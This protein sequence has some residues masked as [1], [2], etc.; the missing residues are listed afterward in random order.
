VPTLGEFLAR[1]LA[2]AMNT[3]TA[4]ARRQLQLSA[5]VTRSS[6]LLR[7]RVDVALEEQNQRLL[8]AI[9]RR[10]R[11]SLR[12]QQTV[13]GLSIAALTYY[14]AGLV[15]YLVKPLKTVFPEFNP[16]WVTAAAV[17]VLAFTIWRAVHRIRQELVGK[18]G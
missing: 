6:E 1:R 7:T 10:G 13:E 2:P 9:D 3:V 14:A 18:D 8:V 12:L 15:G 5:R 11:V 17:P 16:D 4:T